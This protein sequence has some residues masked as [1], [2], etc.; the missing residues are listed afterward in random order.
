MFNRLI[1]LTL[2]TIC[3]GQ[4]ARF[5]AK[6]LLQHLL[7]EIIKY[8]KFHFSLDRILFHNVIY[9]STIRYKIDCDFKKPHKGAE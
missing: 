7:S 8:R 4:K 3:T 9:S 5:K 6:Q 1:G 2:E